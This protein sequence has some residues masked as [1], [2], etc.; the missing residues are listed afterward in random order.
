MPRTRSQSRG[1]NKRGDSSQERSVSGTRDESVSPPNSNG[2]RLKSVVKTVK[3]TSVQRTRSSS[4]ERRQKKCTVCDNCSD[5]HDD[6]G[7][8]DDGQISELDH[9]EQGEPLDYQDVQSDSSPMI[10]VDDPRGELNDMDEDSTE[11]RN[12]DLSAS[13]RHEVGLMDTNNNAIS[14]VQVRTSDKYPRKRKASGVPDIKGQPKSRKGKQSDEVASSVQTV[15]SNPEALAKVMKECAPVFAKAMQDAATSSAANSHSSPLQAVDRSRAGKAGESDIQLSKDFQGLGLRSMR[16]GAVIECQPTLSEATIYTRACEQMTPPDDVQ[17]SPDS[18]NTDKTMVVS[19]DDDIE[20]NFSGRA[21]QPQQTQVFDAEADTRKRARARAVAV[22]REAENAK[23]TLLK[24]PGEQVTALSLP[25]SDSND[26]R[27]LVSVDVQSSGV[28]R[29]KDHPSDD[30]TGDDE[31]GKFMRAFKIDQEFSSLTARVNPEIKMRIERGQYINLQRL[32]PKF[33]VDPNDDHDKYRM[34]SKDGYSYFVDDKESSNKEDGLPVNSISRWDQA[35]RVYAAIYLEANPRKVQELAE[36]TQNIHKWSMTYPW[37]R[38]Y[39]YDI[40]FR[41]LVEKK[42]T[43]P[44]DVIHYSYFMGQF[45]ENLNLVQANRGSFSSPG[46]STSPFNGV[47]GAAVSNSSGFA[48]NKKDCCFRFNK[49]GKCKFG[50]NCNWKHKCYLCGL[51]NH[52]FN[53]CRFRKNRGGKAGASHDGNS[54][55]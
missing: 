13:D 28:S 35:F 27:P 19:A 53:T 36:Y 51:S 10:G 4:R 29:P 18:D 55:K 31:H 38:V 26:L 30:H 12:S 20:F 9:D 54:P 37:Q 52:G 44:W 6:S 47:T 14:S 15:L 32:L 5:N 45:G 21:P 23:S 34:V 8:P 43:R 46:S 11:E 41:Q 16:N 1:R 25:I 2:R 49:T 7:D 3:P 17:V 48:L 50:D 42:P 39:N 24:P 22:V 40:L 33:R